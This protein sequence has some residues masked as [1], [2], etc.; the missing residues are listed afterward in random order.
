MSET[1]PETCVECGSLLQGIAFY[2]TCVNRKCS[3]FAITV[4]KPDIG[5]WVSGQ[6]RKRA[7]P[8][9]NSHEVRRARG[10]M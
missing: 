3:Q 9:T 1:T 5:A 6:S 10:A 2:R 7:T 4:S 8:D